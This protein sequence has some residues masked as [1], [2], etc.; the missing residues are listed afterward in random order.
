MNLSQSLLPEVDQEMAGTRKILERVPEDKFAWKPH[1]KSFSMGALAQHVAT[2]P[3]WGHMTLEGDQFDLAGPEAS[4]FPAPVASQ[5][6]LLALFDASAAKFR[7][8]LVAAHDA[9]LQAQWSLVMGSRVIFTMPRLAVLRS[10]VMNHMIH[11]RAQL[12]V[13]LRLNDVPLPGLY[14][15]SAYEK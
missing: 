12:G 14:G 9:Q 11:H 3:L 13:Y 6:E 7:A 1:A 4:N 8:A 2:I 5:K 10:S 15:P